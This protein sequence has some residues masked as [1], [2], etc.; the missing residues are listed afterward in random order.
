MGVERYDVANVAWQLRFH[1]FSPTISDSRVGELD[2][3][4]SSIWP[5]TVNQCVP[6]KIGIN[7][8][9]QCHVN[10]LLNGVLW[11]QFS[12]ELSEPVM[13]PE[14]ISFRLDSMALTTNLLYH[15]TF[16]VCERWNYI[17]AFSDENVLAQ[18]FHFV[19]TFY[20]RN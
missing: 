8:P 16:P 9:E 20:G 18:N 2:S 14:R 1:G 12:E 19:L 13:K 17:Y 3:D 11:V 7:Y 15:F 4:T 10:V 6:I 5:N